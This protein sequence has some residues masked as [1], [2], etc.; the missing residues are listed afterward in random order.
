MIR[1]IKMDSVWLGQPC[2]EVFNKEE[3]TIIIEDLEDTLKEFGER[4]IGLSANQIGYDKRVAIIRI[5]AVKLNL[6][7]PEIKIRKGRIKFREGCLSYPGISV[8]T[9]RSENIVVAYEKNG[10]SI[11]EAWDGFI[12]IAI[13]HEIDHLNGRTIFQRKWHAR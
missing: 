7:N 9:S 6:I 11:E 10:E 1:P 8:E 12:S 4:A 13:Q 2:K 5:G 3:I